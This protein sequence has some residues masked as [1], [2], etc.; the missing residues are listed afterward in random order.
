MEP[1]V[2]PAEPKVKP[3]KPVTPKPS[4]K[5]SPFL[6]KVNPDIETKPKA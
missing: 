5:D 4:R 1:Q 2:K 3:A 6:P